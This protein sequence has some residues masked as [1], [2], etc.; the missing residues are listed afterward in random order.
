MRDLQSIDDDLSLTAEVRSALI[1][2]GC[3]ASTWRIDP[4]LDERLRVGSRRALP[5]R[6][7][8]AL[9]ERRT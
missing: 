7:H 3:D 5:G 1:A 2:D 6:S 9:P 8:L 4:L